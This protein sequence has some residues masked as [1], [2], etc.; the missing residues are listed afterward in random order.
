M[1][2]TAKD[3]FTYALSASYLLIVALLLIA[4]IVSWFMIRW[5]KDNAN[6]KGE[7]VPIMVG[8]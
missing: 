7:V 6:R 4:S 1:I 3:A 8:S 5:E 2:S